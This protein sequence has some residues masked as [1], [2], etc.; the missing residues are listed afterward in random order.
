MLRIFSNIAHIIASALF[1]PSPLRGGT[2][3]GGP[4]VTRQTVPTPA[5]LSNPRHCPY[6]A[7]TSP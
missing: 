4:S 2:E 5:L 3:G 6:P 7:R 1:L